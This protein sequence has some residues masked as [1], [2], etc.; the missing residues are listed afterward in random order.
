MCGATIAIAPYSSLERS[1]NLSTLL[2]SSNA[3]PLTSC[4]SQL[5]LAG[6]SP[7]IGPIKCLVSQVEEE[8]ALPPS[9]CNFAEFDLGSTNDE[10]WYVRGTARC[11]LRSV[12]V[13][14]IDF[15]LK[16]SL[17]LFEKDCFLN[18]SRGNTVALPAE[19]ACC[20]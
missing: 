20:C 14:I 10:G 5:S 4:V 12:S 18:G 6:R 9:A 13:M 3:G 8:S 16:V 17:I 19:S 2:W 7:G 15:Y 1:S 11:A